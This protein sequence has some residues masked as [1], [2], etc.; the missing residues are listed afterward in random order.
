M[1]D[2]SFLSVTVLR[3]RIVVLFLR[4]PYSGAGGVESVD[5]LVDIGAVEKPLAADQP[6]SLLR[7]AFG[8]GHAVTTL[9]DKE[10]FTVLRKGC[11]LPM[12]RRPS[13]S[14]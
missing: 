9:H 3:D 14:R 5:D 10:S 12:I 4:V 2:R 6:P 1:F 13:R 8:C 7:G 11:S